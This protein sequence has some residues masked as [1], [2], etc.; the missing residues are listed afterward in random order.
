MRII[1]LIKHGI[2]GHALLK[3]V[4]GPKRFGYAATAIDSDRITINPADRP[5]L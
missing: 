4:P 5:M 2:L 3:F 1:V